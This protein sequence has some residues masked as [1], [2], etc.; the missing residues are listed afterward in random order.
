MKA[1]LSTRAYAATGITV[2]P[3]IYLVGWTTIKIE[4]TGEATHTIVILSKLEL[5]ITLGPLFMAMSNENSTQTT[6]R[7]YTPYLAGPNQEYIPQR[8]RAMMRQQ[9]SILGTG[10][11]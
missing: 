6:T 10:L 11:V 4:G 3:E 5:H 7:G 1:E 9:K 2:D 8:L